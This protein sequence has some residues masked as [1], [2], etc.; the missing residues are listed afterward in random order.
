MSVNKYPYTTNIISKDNAIDL[1]CNHIFPGE[2]KVLA[3]KRVRQ[4]IRQAQKDKHL[5]TPLNQEHFNAA[6]FFKW[7]VTSKHW[8]SLSNIPG[9]PLSTT[10]NISGISGEFSLGNVNI[11]TIPTNIE[12]LKKLLED[13]QIRVQELE[14]KVKKLRKKNDDLRAYKENIRKDKLIRSEK[15]RAAGEKGGRGNEK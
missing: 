9:L 13:C 10:V 3:H 12:G 4:R 6:E 15:A 14:R 5:V 11:T 7:A 1:I 8:G 2:D